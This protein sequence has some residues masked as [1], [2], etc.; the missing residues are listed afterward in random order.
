MIVQLAYNV[1]KNP[2]LVISLG[3]EVALIIKVSHFGRMPRLATGGD[4]LL[5]GFRLTREEWEG[6]DDESREILLR[7]EE[8]RDD[9]R[10]SA[11]E[12]HADHGEQDQSVG[13]DGD[14]QPYISIEILAQELEAELEAS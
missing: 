13:E 6:L 12:R 7:A 9:D 5:A 1:G 14:D 10:G 2:T 3:Q 8:E 4:V 11:M